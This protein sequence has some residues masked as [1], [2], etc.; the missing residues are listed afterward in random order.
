VTGGIGLLLL[1]WVLVVK[2][3]SGKRLSLVGVIL[4]FLAGW[5]VFQDFLRITEL[6]PA[7]GVFAATD[8]GIYVTLFGALVALVGSVQELL[9]NETILRGLPVKRI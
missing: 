4:A 6:D 7:A 9:Q 3:R 1:L 8:V 2:G 5:I